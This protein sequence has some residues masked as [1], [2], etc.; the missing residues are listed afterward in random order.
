MEGWEGKGWIVVLRKLPRVRGVLRPLEEFPILREQTCS[1]SDGWEQP[2]KGG[3]GTPVVA[4]QGAEA[5]VVPWLLRATG[6]LLRHS[7]GCSCR[8]K[9]LLETADESEVLS[10]HLPCGGAR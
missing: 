7:Q 6:E 5:G 3:L 2:G 8:S 9:A 4:S 10:Q 1:I